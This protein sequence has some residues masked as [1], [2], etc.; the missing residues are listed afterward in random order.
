MGKCL[1]DEEFRGITLCQVCEKDTRVIPPQTVMEPL[2]CHHQAEGDNL[3]GG[4]EIGPSS[5][6]QATP[7]STY[8][9]STDAPVQYV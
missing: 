1:Y 4:V 3:R 7:I 5:V 2:P 8:L 6:S 9:G